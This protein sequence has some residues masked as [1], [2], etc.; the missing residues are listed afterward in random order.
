[1]NC[2]RPF[3]VLALLL[4]SLLSSGPAA[5]PAATGGISGRVQN[6]ISGKFLNNA[7]ITVSGTDLVA[8]TD[9]YGTYRLANVPVGAAVLEVFYTGLDAQRV[10]VNVAAGQVATQDFSLTSAARLGQGDVVR[11]DAFTVATARETDNDSIAI[12]EQRFAP[13]LRSV[14]SVDEF[15][16]SPDGNVAEFLKFLP[17]VNVN[18]AREVS[19]NG[20]PSANVPVTIGGFSV[21]SVIGSGGDGGTGRTNSMDLFTTSNLSRIE[22]SFSPTPESEGADRKSTR[23]NSSH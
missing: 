23:L 12:N 22:V 2:P 5:Q 11:L 19:I 9:Q 14:V 16:D 20:V 8:F 15:G 1:M 18:S 21:A 7:R 3:L 6:F 10:T 4:G 17:G 13:N